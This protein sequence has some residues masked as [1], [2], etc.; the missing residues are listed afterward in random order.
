MLVNKCQKRMHA[1]ILRDCPSYNVSFARPY[2]P[3]DSMQLRLVRFLPRGVRL[4][5][6]ARQIARTDA[7]RAQML[8]GACGDSS[9]PP[10]THYACIAA[11]AVPA[12]QAR[13]RLFMNGRHLGSSRINSASLSMFA[14]NVRARR[15]R[16]VRIKLVYITAKRPI[17]SQVPI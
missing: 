5:S 15:R 2:T 4:S 10:P 7:D 16:T 13:V 9:P 1:L 11:L 8:L 12:K 6:S 17:W 14:Q 3:L